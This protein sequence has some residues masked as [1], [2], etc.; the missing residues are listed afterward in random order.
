MCF[1]NDVSI[2]SA[3]GSNESSATTTSSSA[4]RSA[5]GPAEAERAAVITTALPRALAG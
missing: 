2:T 3:T 4:G 1:R 5:I